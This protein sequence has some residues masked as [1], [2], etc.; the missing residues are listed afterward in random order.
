MVYDILKK[1]EEGDLRDRSRTPKHQ[2]R[3]TPL[4][5][6]DRVIEVRNRTHLGPE[7]LAIYLRDNEDLSA[8]AGTIR[9]ILRRNRVGLDA[10]C[11]PITSTKRSG[12]L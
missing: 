12:S 10:T 5:V 6:E 1:K 4:P 3:R 8:P 7:R 11:N 9:H 2:P